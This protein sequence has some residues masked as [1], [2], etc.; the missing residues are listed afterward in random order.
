MA[1][2]DLCTVAQ[3]KQL[4][5]IPDAT[6]TH[7]ALLARLVS[8]ASGIFT[9]LLDMPVLADDVDE[10]HDGTGQ[11]ALVLRREP[12][13]YVFSVTVA[14]VAIP[15]AVTETDQGWF[16]DGRILRL[17]GYT[18]LGGRAAVRVRYQAG[19]DSDA[20][21][22]EIVGVVADTAALVFRQRDKLGI[23]SETL[24]GQT[25]AYMKQAVS[26][27]AQAVLDRRRNRVPS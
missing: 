23:S 3:V 20:V 1:D 5:A 4:L 11:D 27:R 2:G 25:I 18:F 16:L 10:R 6:T 19:Y 7:D 22:D 17:R 14:G 8:E 13:T 21:P 26:D 15:K 24:A 9:T 12:V